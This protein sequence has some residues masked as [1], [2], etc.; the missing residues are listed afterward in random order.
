MR[1]KISMAMDRTA[2]LGAMLAAAGF[3]SG[4]ALSN[5]SGSKVAGTVPVAAAHLSGTVFGGQQPVTASTIQLYSVGTLGPGSTSTPLLTKTVTTDNGGGF[6]IT[7]DYSCASATEVYIVATGG[8][9]GSGN[10]TALSLMAVLGPCSSLTSSTNIDMNELT[11]VAAVFAL[12]PFMSSYSAVGA[13][14]SYPAGLVNAFNEAQVLVNTASGGIASASAGITLP[15]ARLNTL[16][17]TL[18]ACVNT[19][20]ATSAT[21]TSLFSATSATETIGAA[22]AMAQSPGSASTTGLW[23]LGSSTPPF[24]PNLSAQPNDF[25][26]AVN[27]T[28][29]E[30]A[31]PY[32]IAMDTGGNAWVTNESG[33]S[34]VKLP[35]LS[36]GFATTTYG[37][38]GLLAPRGIS[39]DRQGNIWI[40]NTGGNDVVEL[41]SA[42]AILSGS[43]YTA[44]GISGPVAIAN[45]SAGN[46]WVANFLGGSVTELGST[47]TPS[48]VSPISNSLNAPSSIAIDSTGR[49][50]VGNQGS[51]ALC[52]LSN[53]G[54]LQ[55]CANDGTLFGTTAVAVSTGGNVVMAGST[56]G[57]SVGGAFTLATNTGSVS[58]SSPVSGGGLTLPSAVA[59]DGN[60]TAWFANTTSISAF[61]GSSAITGAAGFGSVNSPAGIAVDAS[62]NV[63]TANT[64]DNSVTV[65]IGV[66]TPV[67]TPLAVSVGP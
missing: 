51:G 41:S 58:A 21:C 42:G 57:A 55:E 61:S 17:N 67:A 24:A 43:G 45:D 23:S 59:F 11:T 37:S 52:L 66:A 64:G 26:L 18:A 33:S 7:S 56:T 32:G 48:G 1:I 9:A 22:L 35:S 19:S 62:G 20:G 16:A 34:V 29:A 3:L 54:V 31:G 2:A 28:G 40:A 39:I 4:C 47:G 12:A 44:G 27:Y 63:W 60:G 50:A 15:V 49:V 8:N 30:L 14:G 36:N 25:T 6:S 65:F 5:G 13:T 53:A 46:A 38:A 10:N